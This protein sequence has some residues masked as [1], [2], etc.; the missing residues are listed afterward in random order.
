LL[1]L[2][3][4]GSTNVI[5]QKEHSTQQELPSSQNVLI[6]KPTY[7]VDRAHF[8]T[9]IYIFEEDHVAYSVQKLPENNLSL[10]PTPM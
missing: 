10:M 2:L 7:E 9:L 4:L 6:Q 5:R 1:I 8:R 3:D